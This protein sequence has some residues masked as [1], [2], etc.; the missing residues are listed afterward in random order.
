MLMMKQLYP[1]III[2]GLLVAVEFILI[3]FF[4]VKALVNNYAYFAL[5]GMA[6]IGSLFILAVLEKGRILPAVPFLVLDEIVFAISY[7]IIAHLVTAQPAN[8][9]FSLGVIRFFWA[10]LLSLI[11]IF[12]GERKSHL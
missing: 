4:G 9:A 10:F 1:Y 3:F 2:A 11:V 8:Y 6:A 5:L 7:V 12:P